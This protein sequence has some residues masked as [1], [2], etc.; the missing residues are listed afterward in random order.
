MNFY[1]FIYF[2]WYH[3]ILNKNSQFTILDDLLYR[4]YFVEWLFFNTVDIFV[5]PFNWFIY[6]FE[7]YYYFTSHNMVLHDSRIG[8]GNEVFKYDDLHRS[9]ELSSYIMMDE[10]LMF[11]KKYVF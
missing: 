8:Y 3:K 6:Y 1:C 2:L 5:T 11:W 10:E 9:F 7:Y 4:S